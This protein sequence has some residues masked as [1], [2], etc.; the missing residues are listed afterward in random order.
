M[1]RFFAIL[2]TMALCLMTYGSMAAPVTGWIALSDSGGVYAEAAEG[3]RAEFERAQPGKVA[4]PIAHSTQFRQ[5]KPEPQWV[6]AV[7]IAALRDMQELFADNPA[8]PPLLINGTNSSPIN[9]LNSSAWT[10]IGTR[11]PADAPGRP[12]SIPC[13]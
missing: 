8:P 12:S 9:S 10:L 1:R 2:A 4:W 6:V 13:L 7:G 11:A 3:L 5:A